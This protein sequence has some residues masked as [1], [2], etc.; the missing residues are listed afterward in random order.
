[1]ELNKFYAPIFAW[2]NVLSDLESGGMSLHDTVVINSEN[3]GSTEN[4]G[5]G[6]KY[7]G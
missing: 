4:Q 7:M 5:A 3:C 2:P 6:V 1:M